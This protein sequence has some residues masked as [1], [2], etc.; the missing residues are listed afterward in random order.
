M[1][2]G[3][4]KSYRSKEDQTQS[5]PQS[6]FATNF[7]DH[8][9]AHNFWKVCN[10]YG[11]IVD[12][13]IP[14]KKSKAGKRFAFVRFIKV[15]NID[16]LVMNLCAIWIGRFH[17]HENVA[18]VHRERKTYAPSHPLMLI[19]ERIVWISREGVPLKVWTRN[20]FAKVAS[21]WGDLVEWEDLSEKS[22]FFHA[23]ETEAWDLFIC[24]D[25]YESGSSDDDDED[26]NDKGSQSRYKVTSDNDVERV[27][28]SKYSGDDLKYPP[29]F[30]PSMI[31]VE[32]VNEKE[33]WATS[34]EVS[35]HVNSTLNK[36]EEPVPKGK[37]TSN[38]S[39][40]SKRVHMGGLILQLMDEL[41]K[42]IL[43]V[44][45]PTLFVKD[46]VTSSDNFLVVMGSWVPSSSKLLIISVYA[47]QELTEKRV[48]WDYI[49]RLIDRWDRDC[50]IM[51]DFNK[52]R[53][54]QEIYGL[55]FHVQGANA[56]NSFISLASLID[57][58][59]DGYTYTWAYKTT[60]KM[61]KLDRFL[62]SKGLLASFLFL[63][64]LFLDRYLSDHH[65]VLMRELS[66]Y[67]VPAPFRLFHS[68]FNLDGFDK[69]VEDTSKSLV[70][71]D[72]N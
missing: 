51:R 19:D 33:K 46:N 53:T 67:Y 7:L 14:Y 64:A 61:S 18:R 32:E 3:N 21:K 10:D 12:A 22:L 57:L 44:W 40:C 54:E 45:E 17:L 71:V 41:V 29:G 59:L 58:P 65:H 55:A 47:P 20:T 1:G 56:F 5:I 38:D 52:V 31:N 28:E 34:N 66:I 68:W 60:I 27:S 26:A 72:S 25:T 70:T 15:D 8:V 37:L 43:C 9:T 24:N 42:G 35:D 50:V 13:F 62:I 49:L 30:K 69:M 39:V 63:L 6:V 36:L 16:R 2:D 23:K 4:W 11:V 48:L